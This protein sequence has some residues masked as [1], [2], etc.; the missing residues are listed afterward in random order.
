M[1]QYVYW[2]YTWGDKIKSGW[3][4]NLLEKGKIAKEDL[5]PNVELFA[6]YRDAF[7]E[8]CTCRIGSGDGPIPFTSVLEYFKIYGSPLEDFDEF[9]YVIRSMDSKL[10][11]LISK[12]R[13]AD[14]NKKG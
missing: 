7:L 4:D 13:E 9:L 5:Q 2:A 1:S 3:Y 10:L 14:S 8:L 12:K 11:D 6:H